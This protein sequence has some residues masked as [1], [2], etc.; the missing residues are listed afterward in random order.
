MGAYGT[1]IL[2][3]IFVGFTLVDALRDEKEQH[4]HKYKRASVQN[5]SSAVVVLAPPNIEEAKKKV[6][7]ARDALTEQEG[8]VKALEDAIGSGTDDDDYMAALSDRD[9]ARNALHVANEQ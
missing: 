8:N 5:A 6:E 7:E 4:R 1:Y 2:L 3:F 9:T